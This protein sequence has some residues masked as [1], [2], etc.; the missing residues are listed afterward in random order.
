MHLCR[1]LHC[2]LLHCV[3]FAGVLAALART[4]SVS[5]FVGVNWSPKF[6]LLESEDQPLLK[7]IHLGL[8]SSS[9]LQRISFGTFRLKTFRLTSQDRLQCKRLC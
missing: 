7:M 9:W 4:C 5:T 3:G 6:D 8:G 1:E 2:L